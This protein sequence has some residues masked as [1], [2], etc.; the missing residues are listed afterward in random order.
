MCGCSWGRT[1]KP[2]SSTAMELS[3]NHSGIQLS[4]WS[5]KWA[6]QTEQ[7]IPAPRA[8]WAPSTLKLKGFWL[9]HLSSH[10]LFLVL[11][12][13][14][15]GLYVPLARINSACSM[16][17]G[18]PREGNL[19]NPANDRERIWLLL[20]E[21]PSI[22]AFFFPSIFLHY[23]IKTKWH[24][25]TRSPNNPQADITLKMTFSFANCLP[26]IVTCNF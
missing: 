15:F 13:G 24:R 5:Y 8:E 21:T 7:L 26:V 10:V 12:T 22:A 3:A 20:R 6:M 14:R 19:L 4:G 16:D 17:C 9:Y 25:T 1:R 11:V 23:C 2:Y 18:W